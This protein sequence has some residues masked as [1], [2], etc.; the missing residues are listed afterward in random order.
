LQGPVSEAAALTRRKNCTF[1]PNAIAKIHPTSIEEPMPNDTNKT[2]IA[3]HFRNRDDAHRAVIELREV[4]FPASS[5]GAAFREGASV[6]DPVPTILEPEQIVEPTDPANTNT[7]PLLPSETPMTTLTGGSPFGEA[8]TYRQPS[9]AEEDWWEGMRV[10]LLDAPPRTASAPAGST[11]P[12]A[13]PPRKITG[14]R[15][16]AQPIDINFE[17]AERPAPAY[18]NDYQTGDYSYE[19]HAFDPHSLATALAAAGLAPDQASMIANN[20]GPGESIVTV[21]SAGRTH[22]AR[23]IL[24]RNNG[25]IAKR[26][27]DAGPSAGMVSFSASSESKDR[28]RLYGEVLRCH[29]ESHT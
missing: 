6:S 25:V 27:N 11:N 17:P 21:A 16:A 10:A 5:I 8:S 20:I 28:L 15:E 9:P 19:I 4:E 23:S 22:E 3:A 14:P 1:P 29:K 7:S 12:E 26:A 18:D 2:T 13:H 24:V